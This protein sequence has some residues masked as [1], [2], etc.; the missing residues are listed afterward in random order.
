MGRGKKASN[1]KVATRLVPCPGEA[2]RNAYI[3]HCMGC[4][5]RWGWVEIPAE[6]ETLEAYDEWRYQQRKS[7][8][9]GERT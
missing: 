4:A 9:D 5:P 1:G 7:A 8:K 2:H 3:D 6:F